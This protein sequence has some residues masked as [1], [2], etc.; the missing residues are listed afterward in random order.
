[1]KAETYLYVGLAVMVLIVGLIVVQY[2]RQ[3]A[4]KTETPTNPTQM[5]E[6]TNTINNSERIRAWWQ[7]GVKA[8]RQSQKAQAMLEKLIAEAKAKKSVDKAAY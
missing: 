2:R 8:G 7:A 1:M 4:E 6:K 3:M 5:E